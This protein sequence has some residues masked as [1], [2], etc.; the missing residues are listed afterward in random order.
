MLLHGIKLTSRSR[1]RVLTHP[2]RVQMSTMLAVMHN[3]DLGLPTTP[4]PKVTE[5]QTQG[6]LRE[7]VTHLNLAD[8]LYDLEAI[9]TE[10]GE[11]DNLKINYVM[12]YKNGGWVRY[13][14]HRLHAIEC[15]LR[16]RHIQL[17]PAYASPTAIDLPSCT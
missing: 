3:H 6:H 5:T 2:Q 8:Y 10:T 15:I 16:V 14:L 13:E 17:P 7:K 1:Q 4:M 9:A 11:L 12:N